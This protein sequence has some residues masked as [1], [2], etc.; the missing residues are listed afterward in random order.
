MACHVLVFS[1]HISLV[2][3]CISNDIYTAI[4]IS[5]V[6]AVSVRGEN[7]QLFRLSEFEKLSNVFLPWS[8]PALE[9]G[10]GLGY[11]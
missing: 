11:V 8:R 4:I 5:C 6:L 9:L 2:V 10:L 3:S 7:T 1:L